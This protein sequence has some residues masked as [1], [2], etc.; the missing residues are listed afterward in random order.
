MR[1]LSTYRASRWPET[2]VSIDNQ[3]NYESGFQD[4]LGLV[5]YAIYGETERQNVPSTYLQPLTTIY[6]TY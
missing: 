6:P 2:H 3:H 4:R 1:C 5:R